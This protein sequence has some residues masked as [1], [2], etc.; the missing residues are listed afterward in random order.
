MDFQKNNL[1]NNF[2]NEVGI[3]FQLYNG[4][5]TA[6]PFHAIEHTGALLNSLQWQC[7]AGYDAGKSPTDILETFFS[8]MP[9]P[10]NDTEQK[11]LMFRIIQYAERQVVLFDAIEDAAFNSTHDLH[12]AG[13]LDHIIALAR[14]QHRE[15]HIK[16]ILN[17]FSVLLVLTAHPTQFQKTCK[18]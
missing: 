9:T 18:P 1:L 16:D 5:F 2:R 7:M 14:N 15:Q 17:D 12:G 11:D 10:L 3:T 8:S 4:L 6:L 13:T